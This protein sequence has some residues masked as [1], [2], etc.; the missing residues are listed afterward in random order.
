MQPQSR[1]T[2][3]PDPGQLTISVSGNRDD[4]ARIIA[5]MAST[6]GGAMPTDVP[7]PLLLTREQ[8]SERTGWGSNKITAYVAEGRLTN[9]GSRRKLLISP[10]ELE[11][12]IASG[13]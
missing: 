10:R 11:E 9:R 5:S 8:V 12:L 2:P 1:R 6:L 3:E 4:V 13:G 7:S